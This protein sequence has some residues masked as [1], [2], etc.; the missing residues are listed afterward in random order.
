[1]EL[2]SPM[3]YEEIILNESRD[4]KLTVCLRTENEGASLKRRPAILILPGGGYTFLSEGEAEVVATPYLEAGYQAFVLR[5]SVGQHQTWP[6]PLEDYDQAMEFIKS[7]SEKWQIQTDKIAVLGFSAGGHLAG[8]AATMAKHRP[9]AAILGYAALNQTTANICQPVI[10]AP[11]D[12]V[13]EKTCPCFLFSARDDLMVPIENTLAF[14]NAL[15]DNGIMFETH[16]YAYG[17]HGF[18]IGE[19]ASEICSRVPNW[20]K[21]SIGWLED[22][23][24][25][26]QD[27][28]F[29]EP[30]CPPKMN[31]DAD[32][33][34]SVDCTIGHLRNQSDRIEELL[35]EAF[36]KVDE[37]VAT[38]GGI[39]IDMKDIV[40]RLQLKDLLRLMEKSDETVKQIDE[41]LRKITKI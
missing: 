20:L 6:N 31:G 28:G 32:D 17:G 13:D 23:F 7:N 4:V 38:R 27:D 36:L 8:C 30:A 25:V 41:E 16:I 33:V 21:D 10:P 2:S 26:M 12:F 34:L 39:D 15:V 29:S 19:D 9:N 5:Y 14:E 3:K 22:M 35:K 11:V 24:G 18:S 1:M 40:T 37:I